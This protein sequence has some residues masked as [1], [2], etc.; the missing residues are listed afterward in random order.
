M[1][2]VL[3]AGVGNVLRRDDG[4]GVE[5]ARRLAARG[6]LLDGVRVLESGIAGISLVQELYE[7]YDALIIVDAVDRGGVPGTTYVLEPDVRRIETRDDL[8]GCSTDPA[9]ALLLA[10]ALGVLPRKVL[11]FGAQAAT[12]DELGIGLTEPLEE[13]AE[14]AVKE[15]RVL[16]R[17]LMARMSDRPMDSRVR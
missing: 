16:L 10:K 15:L 11:I 2:K 8:G 4:F 9:K 14:R 1:T 5:V 7:G 12:C 6:G 3:V 17:E 13:A